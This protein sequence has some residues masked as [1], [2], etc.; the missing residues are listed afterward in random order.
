MV[1]MVKLKDVKVGQKFTYT[2]GPV[3]REMILEYG[4]ASGDK[5][6]IHMN[7]E[8]AINV[9]KLGGVIAHGMLSFGILN[10]FISDL[11]G[12]GKVISTYAEMR[13]MIRPGDS[14][15]VNF[16]VK[17]IEGKKVTLEVL[18]EGK[19]QLRIEKG[20]KVVKKFEADEKN[21]FSEKEIAKGILNKEET[22]DG[23]I[24][25][26]LRQALPGEAVVELV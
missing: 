9:G 21:W 2:Y 7:E 23:T 3:T 17:K 19:T 15:I 12:D 18:E 10:R 1:K 13:G 6:P 25:V 16:T 5:N 8:F 22:K 24:I 26:F 20:G 14:Y 4:N 11:V